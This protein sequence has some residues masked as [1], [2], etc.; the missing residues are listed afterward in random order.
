[1]KLK[2]NCIVQ[3]LDDIIIKDPNKG[4]T[5]ISNACARIR[6]YPADAIGG[7]VNCI[8]YHS[9]DFLNGC[10]D[11]KLLID[12]EEG[13]I[14]TYNCKDHILYDKGIMLISFKETKL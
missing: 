9:K 11:I 5:M 3:F 2:H 13:E 6:W 4:L 8:L 1:M 14:L 7:C 10:K 12:G